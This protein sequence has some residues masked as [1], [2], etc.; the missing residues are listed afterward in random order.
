MAAEKNGNGDGG[1]GESQFP[2]FQD[3]PSVFEFLKTKSLRREKEKACVIS[4]SLL[5]VS[6]LAVNVSV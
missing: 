5:R 4:D 3:C 2:L 6:V 1:E